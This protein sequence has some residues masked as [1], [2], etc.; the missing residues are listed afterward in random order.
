MIGRSFFLIICI[1]SIAAYIYP[2]Q[3]SST[4]QRNPTPVGNAGTAPKSRVGAWDPPPGLVGESGE[5]RQARFK[6]FADILYRKP[7]RQELSLLAPRSET[8]QRY[9]AFLS[10]ADSGIFRLAADI[11]CVYDVQVISV[12]DRCRN[13]TM[14]GS[15]SSY[16]FRT[17][18]Y[19][20]R[21]LSDIAFRDGGIAAAGIWLNGIFA[22]LGGIPIETVALSDAVPRR[23]AAIRP[24]SN[25]AEFRSIDEKYRSGST[26]GGVR[27][28]RSVV[29]NNDTTY[30]MRSIA[31][32]G[33]AKRVLAGVTYNEF[34]FDRRRDVLVVFR[35][36]EMEPDGS[37]TV[38]WR[39]LADIESPRLDLDEEK[40][41]ER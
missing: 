1:L 6:E 5:Y 8:V 35:V 40:P 30:L 28:S 7:T 10:Q 38:L 33:K 34:D 9:K 25:V 19:R 13:R 2:Q 17:K 22:T 24:A 36:T 29:V 12:D 4:P 32:K 23:M 11:G 26:E 3:P 14:P 27:L 20:I 16:S 39:K 41:R 15:G 31:Y 21:E 37:V 18:N